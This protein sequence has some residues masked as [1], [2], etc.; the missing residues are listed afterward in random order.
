M[1]PG[2][3]HVVPLV[4]GVKREATTSRV[5]LGFLYGGIEAHFWFWGPVLGGKGR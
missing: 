5:S 1:A 4:P 2:D 3:M